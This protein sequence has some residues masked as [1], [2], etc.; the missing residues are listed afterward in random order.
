ML[1]FGALVLATLAIHA[2][3]AEKPPVTTEEFLATC[4]TN[5]KACED[6]IYR[7]YISLVFEDQPPKVC[8]TKDQIADK[9]ALRGNITGWIG[10]HRKKAGA[11]ASDSIRAALKAVY[12]CR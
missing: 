2:V 11:S 5:T 10:Q 6:E 4:S 7:S 3:A 8:A 12:P 1:R 9:A